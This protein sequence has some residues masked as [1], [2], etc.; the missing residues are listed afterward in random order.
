MLHPPP[1][2]APSIDITA[3]PF[4][5]SRVD[6]SV[7]FVAALA[8]AS[9]SRNCSCSAANISRR[10]KFLSASRTAKIKFWM[11]CGP[12]FRRDP[13][14]L[15][16]PIVN[17]SLAYFSWRCSGINNSFGGIG[18]LDRSLGRAVPGLQPFVR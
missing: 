12:R 10:S 7:Q 15:A 11:I 5:R 2:A 14:F 1:V 8:M 17:D 4:R 18:E 16:V 6:H 9:W 3:A 13:S